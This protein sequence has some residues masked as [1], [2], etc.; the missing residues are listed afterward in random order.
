MECDSFAEEVTV[1]HEFDVV[2]IGTGSAGT[3]AAFACRQ[4]GKSVAIADKRDFGGTCALRGCDPKKVLVG[5][6]EVVERAQRMAG[7]GIAGDTRIDW[8]Q[9]MAFKRTFTQPVPKD[10]EQGYLDKGIRTF[11]GQASFE[12]AHTI[13]VGDD[14]LTFRNAVIAVGAIPMPLGMPGAEHVI[15]SED[16]LDLEHLPDSIVFIGAGYI[17]FEFAHVA[18]RAGAR[19]TILEQAPV[20]LPQFDADLVKRLVAAGNAIGI[21]V[22]CGTEVVA[23]RKAA[24]GFTVEVKQGERHEEIAAGLV[25][26]GAGRV[27]DLDGLALERGGVTYDKHGIS[28]LPHLQNTGN[29]AVF[30]AGDCVRA[31]GGPPLTPVAGLEGET[32]GKNICSGERAVP[33]FTGVV[34]VVYTMPSLGSVG[35]TEEQAKKKGLKFTTHQGDATQWYS[36]RRINAAAA[37]YKVL[38]GENDDVIGAHILGPHAEEILNVFS[39]AA[40]AKVPAAVLRQTL[41]GW[42]TAASDVE[43]MLE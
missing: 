42:P 1:K 6:A 34:S 9:L 29:T 20:P 33:D 8:A 12:D 10:R 18:R 14:V 13:R 7:H 28:I 2:V 35:L 3:S 16:F 25:V 19:V 22:R 37:Y 30:A 27:P 24:G 39:L 5:A 21:D 43:S 38:V 4:S 11:H 17:S 32:A 23:I 26:H 40:R 15:T 41:F 36:S 31:E